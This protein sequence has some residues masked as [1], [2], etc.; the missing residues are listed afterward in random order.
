MTA[1]RAN[2]NSRAQSDTKSN[3]RKKGCLFS[4][5]SVYSDDKKFRQKRNAESNQELRPHNDS[6]AC[7]KVKHKTEKDHDNGDRNL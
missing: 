3:R 5:G 7:S 1:I 2:K 4:K 6:G